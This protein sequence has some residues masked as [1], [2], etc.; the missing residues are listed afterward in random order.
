MNMVGSDRKYVWQ[1]THFIE[2]ERNYIYVENA[3]FFLKKMEVT[4]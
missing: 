1:I 4:F 3:P 2:I